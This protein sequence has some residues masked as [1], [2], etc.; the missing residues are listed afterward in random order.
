MNTS[1][2]LDRQKCARPSPSVSGD[3]AARGP[4][5]RGVAKL[6]EAVAT[7]LLFINGIRPNALLVCFIHV[8]ARTKGPR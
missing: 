2:P 3:L 5:C 7:V 8:L 1:H 6:R 4:E